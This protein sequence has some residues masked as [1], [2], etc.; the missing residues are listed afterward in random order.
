MQDA[1]SSFP[2]CCCLTK[3][4]DARFMAHLDFGRLVDRLLRRSDL[5]VKWTQGFNPRFKISYQDALPVAMASEGEWVSFSLIED[6]ELT[7]V[8]SRLA[9]VLPDIVRLVDVRRGTFPP[10]EGVV[11]WRAR[12]VDSPG[13]VLDALNE[14]MK[15]DQYPVPDTRH[16]DQTVDARPPLVGG[17]IEDDSLILELRVSAGVPSRPRFVL[18]ALEQ[19][20]EKEGHNLPVFG[21][22]TKV[23]TPARRH[24]ENSWHDAIEVP[25][26][27]AGNQSNARYLSMHEKRMNVALR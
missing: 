27:R 4:G 18:V 24:G 15:R 12:I 14:L 25:A 1:P 8:Q 13:S 26:E 17:W 9:A 5:P 10:V 23:L 20:V 11:T 22:I 19:L 16:P 6:L 21:P 3:D 7:E 2:F